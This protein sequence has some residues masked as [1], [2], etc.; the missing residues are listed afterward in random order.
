PRQRTLSHLAKKPASIS[1]C[2]IKLRSV[3]FLF[4]ANSLSALRYRPRGR[5]LPPSH[6][7]TADTDT[8]NWRASSSC[9]NPNLTRSSLIS[10]E[11]TNDNRRKGPRNR[12]PT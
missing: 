7:C 11:F 8:R 1:V 2:E 10:P 12:L 9:V 6:F 3:Y 5:A 4:L